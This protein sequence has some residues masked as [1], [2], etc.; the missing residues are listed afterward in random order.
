MIGPRLGLYAIGLEGMAIERRGRG[1]LWQGSLTPTFQG[2]RV[3]HLLGPVRW[4]ERMHSTKAPHDLN[5][6]LWRLCC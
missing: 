5:I 1:G 2:L 4:G 6:R 3:G